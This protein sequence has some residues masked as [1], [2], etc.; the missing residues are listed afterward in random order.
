MQDLE[1]F[2]MW[3]QQQSWLFVHR[4]CLE[5]RGLTTMVVRA[6]SESFTA[7]IVVFGVIYEL[8]FEG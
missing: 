1:S 5:T 4:T 7:A 3:L 6:L 8:A 2:H